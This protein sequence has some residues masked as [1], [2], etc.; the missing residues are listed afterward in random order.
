[1]SDAQP[2]QM[3]SPRAR[4]VFA[5]SA[6]V[7]VASLVIAVP[8]FGPR[9][10]ALVPLLLGALG[11]AISAAS[12]KGETSTFSFRRA[13]KWGAPLVVI[14]ASWA[15][16][17]LIDLRIDVTKAKANTLSAESQNVSRNL[18]QPLRIVAF[19]EPG[20]RTETE[21]VALVERYQHEAPQLVLERRSVKRAEDVARANALGVAEL[22][23]L[24]GPN[25]VV[26]IPGDAVGVDDRVGAR[27]RFD[28]GTPSQEEQLTN[29]LREATTTS[30]R[31]RVYV[32]AGHGEPEVRDEGPLGLGR[33]QKD[34]LARNVELVPLPLAMVGMKVPD[35][36]RALLV[37]P[38][39]TPVGSDEEA[40]VRAY[41]DHNGSV[42][43]GADVGSSAAV[44]AIAGS[45]GVTVLD[46]VLVDESPFSG[47]LGADTVTGASQMGHA[48]TR[49]LRGALTHF[50]RAAALAISPIDGR[51][52]VPVISSGS[53]AKAPKSDAHG[54]LPLVIASDGHL[55]AGG[56][57][58][59]AADANFVENAGIG[60][61]ANR[62]L[63]LNIVLW[64]VKDDS[65]IAVHPRAKTGALLFLTPSSRELLA[66][67]LMF[68]IPVTLAAIGAALSALRR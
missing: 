41:V 22:L 32:L 28:A 4:V 50:T 33:L 35:D 21:L 68:L 7:V 57:A 5:V 26:V 13:A 1:M 30:A 6:V 24:G 48:I 31:A 52:I 40:A 54:P 10:Y 42:F 62:D 43:V 55:K 9:P 65:F 27:L 64:L 16:A 36:A 39:T 20:D 59:V 66:F 46:D 51:E 58:V 3:M 23:P 49:P 53:E 2:G 12:A 34:L 60:L 29:A 63:A 15:L 25:V 17:H 67:V 37:L 44:A 14:T 56:R 19:V 8:V 47:L 18:K 61:G 38:G 45:V 11:L